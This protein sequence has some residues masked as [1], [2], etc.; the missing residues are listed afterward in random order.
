MGRPGKYQSLPKATSGLDDKVPIDTLARVEVKDQ[1]IRVLDVL[2]RRRLV[3]DHAEDAD[4]R[5][6]GLKATPESVNATNGRFADDGAPS[7]WR[8]LPRLR[9]QVGLSSRVG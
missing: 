3:R 2:D 5:A 6:A 7:I 1:H 9:R 8:A 4:R